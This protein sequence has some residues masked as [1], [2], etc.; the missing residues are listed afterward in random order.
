ML[1]A[2][3][4]S[5]VLA[6][7]RML[8]LVSQALPTGAFAYSGGLE[9][10]LELGFVR[11]EQ[12]CHT[13]FVPW[14]NVTLSHLDLP[15]FVRIF[16]ALQQSDES[17]ARDQ[18]ARLYASREGAELQ[19]QDRQMARSLHRV[20]AAICPESIPQG[21]VSL[22]YAECLARAA[23]HY[24]LTEDD[25]LLCCA[26]GWVEQHVSALSRLIPLGPI[27][28]QKLMDVCLQLLPS[29]IERGRNLP[30]WDLGASCPGMARACA[31]HETQYTRIFRS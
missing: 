13:F 29:V 17:A 5:G 10:A 14:M 19:M 6:R 2:S 16:R 28:G 4:D 31:F 22:T 26:Y 1:R 7:A 24:G 15:Y 18:S 20:L 25:A 12:D 21:Y 3:F 9:A 30:D 27:A 23:C 8:Q 11:S